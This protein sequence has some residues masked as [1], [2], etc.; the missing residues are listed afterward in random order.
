MLGIFLASIGIMSAMP[1]EGHLICDAIQ[2]KK[3]VQ[4]GNRDFV[5]GTFE[6]IPVTFCL[7]GVGKVSAAVTATILRE[8]F[9]VDEI[10]FTGVAGGG[11]ETEIGDIVV[12]H[13]YLQHDL[14]LQPIFPEFYIYS[15]GTQTLQADQDRIC[16]MMAAAN[17]FL[18]SG[19]SFPD[20]NILEPKAI[21]GIILSGDQFISC[22]LRH[23]DISNRTQKVLSADFHAIEMEGAAVAQVC[24]ELAIP[25]VVVRTIS[26]KADQSANIDF[27]LFIERVA[28]QYSL[29][30]LKEYFRELQLP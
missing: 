11:K 16:K 24:K 1:Q 29:G 2:E 4:V 5:Q 7:A 27:P 3:V 17:R 19:I 21:E 22:P 15:L 13:T 6:G 26:D 10:L 23:Q 12:G 20:L 8:R 25:F 28:N 30:I 9:H 18:N 14:D